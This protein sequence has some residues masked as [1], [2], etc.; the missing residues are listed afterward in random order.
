MFLLGSCKPN[1]FKPASKLL[2]GTWIKS[3]QG[4]TLETWTFTEDKLVIKKG[5][6][7]LHVQNPESG[8]QPYI[9][10]TLKKKLTKVKL[11]M[12]GYF[13]DPSRDP[14]KPVPYFLFL[15]LTKKDMYLYS[16]DDGVKGSI[17]FEF[18]K[19]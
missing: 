2:L 7:T 1:T 5:T 6:D 15:K 10:Y 9:D 8:Y 4:D 17:Q 16:I 12:D 19:Q 18:T 3:P 14:N 11:Y 13:Y